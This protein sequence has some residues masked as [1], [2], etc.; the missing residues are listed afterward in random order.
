MNHDVSSSRPISSTNKDINCKLTRAGIDYRGDVSHTVS[1]HACLPWS[2]NT[3]LNT[4]ALSLTG[5]GS[6]HFTQ[7]SSTCR[8]PSNSSKGPWCY[9]QGMQ[10]IHT[11]FLIYPAN[12]LQN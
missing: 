11:C 1:G 12:G 6:S 4:S 3:I 8:N 7:N 2:E 5:N 9:I 10:R